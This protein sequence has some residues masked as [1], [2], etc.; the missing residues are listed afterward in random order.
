MCKNM[1]MYIFILW[2]LHISQSEVS[3]SSEYRAV[4]HGFPINTQVYF[5]KSNIQ[6]GCSKFK[7]SNILDGIMQNCYN[8]DIPTPFEGK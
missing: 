5:L 1:F 7:F 4:F 3:I 6:S 2:T 8:A